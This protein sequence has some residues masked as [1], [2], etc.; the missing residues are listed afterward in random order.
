MNISI[1]HMQ[2]F[3]R[4]IIALNK[5]KAL[6]YKQGGGGLLLPGFVLVSGEG[7]NP[8]LLFRINLRIL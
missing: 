3:K 4:V 5:S 2:V 7:L 8:L 6:H 1:V